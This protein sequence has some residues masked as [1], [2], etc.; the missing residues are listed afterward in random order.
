MLNEVNEDGLVG[1]EN[2]EHPIGNLSDYVYVSPKSDRSLPRLKDFLLAVGRKQEATSKTLDIDT[3]VP[4]LPGSE[5][6]FTTRQGV[7]R[8]DG[9]ITTVVNTYVNQEEI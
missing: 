2:G 7:N 1:T 9:S 4:T 5:V 8:M 6:A 3:L